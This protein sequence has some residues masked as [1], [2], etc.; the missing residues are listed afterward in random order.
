V[1]GPKPLML[2]PHDVAARIARAAARGDAHAIMPWPFAL[3]RL[4]DRILPRSLRE[5]LLLS[6]APPG[7]PRN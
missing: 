5:R 6:L 2:K 3:L 1:P 4:F 7:E